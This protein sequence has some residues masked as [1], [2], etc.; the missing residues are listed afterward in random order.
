MVVIEKSIFDAFDQ[1][2]TSQGNRNDNNYMIIKY[3]RLKSKTNSVKIIAILMT[4]LMIPVM[5]MS[6]SDA[7]ASNGLSS[8]FQQR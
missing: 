4:V 6:I 7:T 3:N 2:L 1:C 5:I 8:Q